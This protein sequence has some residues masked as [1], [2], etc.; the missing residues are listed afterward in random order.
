MNYENELLSTKFAGQIKIH[1]G[2]LKQYSLKRNKSS[3]SLHEKKKIV[4][5]IPQFAK[6][7][8]K[9]SDHAPKIDQKA[10]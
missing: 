3:S 4:D 1:S 7:E 6:P 9:L 5:K 10:K 2:W 8:K